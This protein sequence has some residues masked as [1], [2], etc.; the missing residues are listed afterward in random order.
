MV[1]QDSS[2]VKVVAVEPIRE[3]RLDDHVFVVYPD[4]EL[5]EEDEVEEDM[6]DDV[7]ES[8]ETQEE[9]LDDSLS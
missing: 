8:V 6:N 9:E 1:D 5:V 2:P 3:P 4:D 7:Q